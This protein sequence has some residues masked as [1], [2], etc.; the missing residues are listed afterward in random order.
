MINFISNI[1]QE[2]KIILS[3]RRISNYY[4][5]E[6][7]ELLKNKF[8]DR[9]DTYNYF[10]HYFWNISPNWLKEHR[11]YFSTDKRGF[12]EDAFHS[13]WYLLLKE[14][15]PKNILEIGVY[16]GQTL[17]LFSLISKHEVFESDICGISPFTSSGDEVSSYLSNLNYY[18]DVKLNFT[19]FKL[20]L[21]NLK[22]GFSTDLEMLKTIQSKKWDLIYID[23][24]HDYDVVKQDFDNC[25]KYLKIGGFLVLD[26]SS[27]YTNYSPPFYS[28]SGHPGP[29]RVAEEID[30]NVFEEFLAVGHN[31]IFRKIA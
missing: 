24:N 27:L 15:Q 12:G 17:S 31:R 8:K 13:M 26:D 2:V 10:H 22:K 4:F 3:R 25:S 19:N 16:R 11:K 23:G 29:S 6:S 28:T 21:P 20:P 30:S 1:L 18:E 7:L 9:A 5:E 14:F